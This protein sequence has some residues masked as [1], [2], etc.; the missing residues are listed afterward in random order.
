M[1][2]VIVGKWG[3]NLAIRL[4]TGVAKTIGLT[5]GEMVEIDI[6]NGDLPIRRSAALADAR[7]Q[8]EAAAQE[9]QAESRKYRL[10]DVSVGALLEEGRRGCDDRTDAQAWG[11]TVG[12]ASGVM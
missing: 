7:Q 6:E 3:K 2:A 5:E 12:A 8:A 9:M 1:T 11:T 4:P 10:G